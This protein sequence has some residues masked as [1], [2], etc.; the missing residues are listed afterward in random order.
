MGGFGE[1]LSFRDFEVRLSIL[2]EDVH[3]FSGLNPF[4]ERKS[5]AIRERIGSKMKAFC[6]GSDESI[7]TMCVK[8]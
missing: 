6:C 8:I 7:F 4:D 1:S 3:G 5:L 2:V